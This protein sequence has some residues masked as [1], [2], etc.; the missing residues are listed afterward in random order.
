MY[1]QRQESRPF[2]VKTVLTLRNRNLT[3]PNNHDY[4]KCTQCQMYNKM[5]QLQFKS[6]TVH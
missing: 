5:Y 6:T 2:G 1:Y 3:E 4:F